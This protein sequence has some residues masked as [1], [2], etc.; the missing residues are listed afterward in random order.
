M[1]V[2]SSA[3]VALLR[4]EEPADAVHL[5]LVAGPVVG[6]AA[7]TLV[8][9]VMVMTG[10]HGVVGASMVA[11][12]VSEYAIDVLPFDAEHAAA[13][14]DAFLRYGK[15]RHPASLNFGDCITYATAVVHG[16]PL[17]CIGADFP[18]TDLP[19]VTLEP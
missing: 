16:R 17:L 15:G 2:D 13:A 10:R 8:E 7:P 11:R 6:I 3:V 9:S 14:Q 12:F 4:R 5:A 19:L 1:I 18:Q